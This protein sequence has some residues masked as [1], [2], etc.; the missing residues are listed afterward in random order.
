MDIGEMGVKIIVYLLVM[1]IFWIKKIIETDDCTFITFNEPHQFMSD[2]LEE[3]MQSI[4]V[5][6]P[7]YRLSPIIAFHHPSMLTKK[8]WDI[9][10]SSSINWLLFKNTNI[11]MYKSVEEQLQPITVEVAMKTKQYE[12][13][14]LPFIGG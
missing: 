9:I 14:F 6:S 4:L 10:Q 7:K 2:G 5:E 11:N 13:I 3:L 1:K 8:L 12:S